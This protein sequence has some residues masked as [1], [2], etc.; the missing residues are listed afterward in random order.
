MSDAAGVSRWCAAILLALSLTA[1][2][3][4][5]ARDSGS[6]LNLLLRAGLGGDWFLLSRS[7]LASREHQDDIFFGYSGAALGYRLNER[8]SLRGGYRHAW[9]RPGDDW[10]EEDRLFA[11][12][13]YADSFDGLRV[14]NRARV[15]WRLFDYR[16]DDV[17]LRNEIT[18][19]GPWSWTSLGL[20][21]YLEEELFY[22]TRAGRVEANW[23]GGGLAWRPAKGVKLKAG[24]RW[25]RFRVGDDWRDRDVLVA[26]L[27]LFF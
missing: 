8:W 22:S 11:E 15:E 4:A 20:R 5:T 2:T 19:E 14:S 18:L 25:N 16:D 6:S 27:N 12:A 9:I 23:L 26:G 21:P 10:L 3:N 1:A 13:Y 7:N 17:R 24:Y